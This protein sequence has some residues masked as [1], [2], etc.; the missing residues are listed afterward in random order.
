MLQQEYI[1]KGRSLAFCGYVIKPGDIK[2][3]LIKLTDLSGMLHSFSIRV[4]KSERPRKKIIID[5]EMAEGYTPRELNINYYLY[6]FIWRLKL[7]SRN[8]ADYIK[9]VPDECFPEI[10]FYPFNSV[11]YPQDI[12][13]VK[14]HYLLYK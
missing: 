7:L 6:E 11:T 3:C 10:F 2:N 5:I 1:Q 13:R 8:F 14:A 4:I 9:I 12:Y